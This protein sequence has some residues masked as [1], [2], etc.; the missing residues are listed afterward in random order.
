MSTQISSLIEDQL[1][2][3]IVSEYEN[4]SAILEAY[5]KQQES[6]GQPLD[7]IGNLT[8]YRDIDFYEKNLLKESTTLMMGISSTATSML[9]ADAT[10]FP[11]RNGYF[12]IGDEICFY[13]TRTDTEFLDVSRGISG[14]TML[15]DL[16]TS[17]TFV[18]SVAKNHS[19]G[20][21]VYNLSH[22]FLYAFVKAFEREYL[23]DVPEVY[24]KGDIDK[25]QLIKNISD[26][27]K[28]KG[29]DKS[30]RF[31]FNTIV[32]RSA[33]DIP[34]TYYPKENT[35]KVSEST[36]D[37][38]FTIQAVILSG[39][40]EWLIGQTIIQ[41]ADKNSPDSPYAS[42]AI[43][44]VS[45]I[46]TVAGYEL[47]D[48]IVNP[49]TVNGNFSIPER[50]TL[51]RAVTTGL[52]I[53]DTITVDSTLGWSDQVGYLQIN[54][55]II[56][57]EGKSARQFVINERGT[58]TRTHNAGDL[59]TNYSNVKSIT[60]QGEVKVL[61]YGI[62]TNL[63][64]TDPQPYSQ[65]GDRVQVSKP[66]F[67]T[68][69]PIIYDELSNNV[70]WKIN[71]TGATPTTP[72]NPGV[73]LSLQKYLADVSA[74]YEDD[75]YYYIATSSYPSTNTF[76]SAQQ[77]TPL[78][79]ANQL[80]L[81]PKETSTTPEVYKTSSRDIGIFVDG[82]IA[83][84]YKS[85]ES[86]AYGNIQNYTLTR[87]GSGYTK[88]PFVLINGESGLAS[89]TLAGDTV[90]TITTTTEKKYTADPVV[91][92]VSGRY[93]QAEAIVTSGEITS[94]RI[95][96]AGEYYSAPP[97][98]VIS[99]LAG[100][101]RFAEYRARIS[102]AGQ[103]LEFEKVSGGKFY[104]QENVRVALVAEGESNPAAATASI[105]RWVKNRFFDKSDILDD[106]GGFAIKDLIENEYYYGV[107]TNP[108]RLRF[109]LGDNLTSTTLVETSTLT[110]SPIL[111]FAYDGNPIYG[112]YGYSNPLDKDSS[113]ARMNSGYQLKTG[114]T[115]GPID[116]PYDMGTF[117][118]DYEWVATVNT[119][120]TR[121]DINN[122]RFCVTPE[123][124][125]GVYAYFLT[126]DSD[127]N[128]V[129]PYILGD[130]FYSLPVRS[131]YE[132]K[133]TQKSIPANSKRL[134][135]PG[136]DK[137]GSNELIFIDAV[138]S[139]SVSS[140]KV[141]DSQPNF[142]VGSR[143]FVDDSDNRGFGASGIVSSTEGKPVV[144]IESK[145]TK[146]SFIT[147]VSS[148][149]AFEGDIITQ[150]GTGATGELI[151]DVAEE[152]EMTL[153]NVTGSFTPGNT[154]SSSSEVINILLSQDSTYTQGETLSLVLF[155]DPTTEI[156]SGE[157]LVGTVDQNAVRLKVTNGDFFDFT[158][159]AEGEVILKSSD[160]GNTPGSEIV[161]INKLSTSID[162]ATVDEDIAI[163]T[164][165]S[166][167]DFG[168]GDILNIEID[169]DEAT[170][171][172]TYYVTKKKFQ[173]IQLI[174]QVYSAKI[175]DTGIGDTTIIGLGKDYINGTY[176]DVPLIF[177]NSALSRDDIVQAKATVVVSGENFDG[178]GNIESI[179]VTDAGSNYRRDDLL[180]I[181]PTAVPK[182]DVTD[183]NQ[184]PSL[185]IEQ[186]NSSEVEAAAQKRFI[187]AE[188]DYENL[189]DNIL[190]EDG[191]FFDTDAGNT[192]I[193]LGH[194]DAT[195]SFNYYPADVE[196][197]PD[198]T[199]SDTIGGIAIVTSDVFYSP[200][201]PL[202]QFE[203]R[204][205]NGNK[206]PEYS[207][208]VGSTITIPALQN[209][210]IY[211]VSDYTTLTGTDGETP[212][213]DEYSIAV[214]SSTDQNAP[215]TFTPQTTGTY[216]YICITHPNA[217]GKINVFPAPTGSFPLVNV[218]AVGFGRGRVDMVVTNTFGISEND[219]ISVGS[220]VVRV[221][222]VNNNDKKLTVERGQEN[223]DVVDHNDGKE[224]TSFRP[225][226]NFTPGARI[227]GDTVND[228]RVVSYDPE[229]NLLIVNWDYDST[230]PN[231]I[232]PVSSILD[233]GTPGKIA[234]VSQAGDLKEKLLFSI[235]QSNFL[236][237]PVV[238][239]QKYY[240]YKFDV[241]HPSMLNSYLDISTSPNF[242]VFTEEKETGLAEPGSPGAFVKIRLGYGP[243]IG[244][245][246]R[247]DVNFTSY[248]YFLTNSSTD[249][250]GSFLRIIDDPL[251]GRKE[252]KFTTPTKL[253]Y[254]I[255]EDPQYDGS[256][257]I[258]Y[259][260]KSIGKIASISLD[261]LGNDY[262]KLPLIK[263]VVPAVGYKATVDVVRDSATNKIV[264]IDIIDPGQ[265]YSK[266]EVVVT[267]GDG[268][269]LH[270]IADQYLG[271]ITQIRILNP[272]NYTSTPAVEIIETDNKLFFE[273]ESIG[274]PQNVKF[275]QYGSGYHSDDTIMSTYQSPLVFALSNFELDA[276]RD[277]EKIQQY[278][279]DILTAEGTVAKS[280]WRTGS[281][282]LR[283]ERITG[284]FM[285]G[286]QIIGK[287]RKKTATISRIISS[288][289]SPSIVTRDKTL[290]T[291]TSDRGKVSSNSQ[292]IHDSDFY[293]DYSYVIRSRTP[294]NNWRNIIKDTTHPAG[295]KVFG[296][297]YMES[298]SKVI[299]PSDQITRK[300]TTFLAGPPLS[301][302]SLST[303]RTIQQKVLKVE[304]SRLR[305][306]LGS[307]STNDFDETLI[308]TREL[309]LTPAFDGRYDPNTGLKIGTQQF[310]ILDKKSGAAYAP[311]N[312]QE[313]LITIDGVAQRPGRSYKV[314]GNQ[315]YFYEA[316]MGERVLED[317]VVPPQTAYIRSFKFREDSDN[318][319]YLKR[320]KNIA[321]SFDGR[322]R[323]FDLHWE[324]G[325]IVKTQV[326]EDLFIYL[327]GI[328]QQGSYE[329]RRFSSPN[330]TDRIA[331]AK[332]PKNYED[333]YDDDAFPQE[334]QNETYFYG[335]GVGLYERFSIDER[336]IPYNDS[337][338]SYIVYDQNNAAVNFTD[339]S[340]V[341]VY[342]DGVLQNSELSYKIIGASIKFNQPIRF[343]EQAD[344]TYI[345]SR[346]DIIRLYGKDAKQTVTFFNYE[347]D[348]FYNRAIVTFTGAGTY[349]TISSWYVLNTTD[350]TIVKQG[351][352]VWG[353]L[354]SIQPGTGNNWSVILKS[355]NIDFVS[356]S[357]VTFDRG[358]DNPQTINFD[359][360][361]ISYV[362]SDDGD[363]ILNRVEANFIPYLSTN[364][365]F[366]S[367][368]YRGEI[369]KEHPE[370]RVGDK[371]KIDGEFE[372]RDILSSPLFARSTDYR[373]SGQVSNSF[374]TKV[375]TSDYNGDKYGEGLSVSAEITGG[376]VVKL[377]WNQ[378]DLS[379]FFNNNILVNPTAYNYYASPI[380][381]FVPTNGEGG[382]AKA[383]VVV[384]G[385]QIIDVVL[386]DGG[387]G[388]TA[389]PKIIVSR[390][391]TVLR[392]NNHPEFSVRRIIVG[393]GADRL[394]ATI[395]S[396]TTLV[397][398]N[399]KIAI[400]SSVILQ[401]PNPISA[402]ILVRR[403]MQPVTPVIGMGFPFEQDIIT[404]IQYVATTQPPAAS[405]QP[406]YRNLNIDVD[407]SQRLDI[408]K[409]ITKS[410][411]TGVVAVNE[412]NLDNPGHFDQGKLG[413][414][415]SSFFDYLF[416]DVGYANVSGI[417]LEQLEITYSQFS[418]ISEGV[419]SWMNNA[420][421]NN[422]S[423]T[424][425]GTLFNPG[426]PSIQETMSY[427]DAPVTDVA[428]VVYL[429]STSF[430]PDSGKILIGKELVTYTGKLADRLTGV[431]R[432]VDGTAAEAHAAGTFVRTIGVETTL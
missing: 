186:T 326:N 305:R 157:I 129:Y 228:P 49:N 420:A 306:G 290:G 410:F 48:L 43:E 97:L 68:K 340:N 322:T 432:G 143:I 280:G 219:L 343:S 419:D 194:D 330:K 183:L 316:P 244:E 176:L 221:T 323:I 145:D 328:L 227:G 246:T 260:G 301:V 237:N 269:G 164:T 242:N 311:Y 19:S 185:T 109:R 56:K 360:Y 212:I 200:G 255:A 14:T 226:Y 423:F 168:I 163:L 245:R 416:I 60:P 266:P 203:F 138:T 111:G 418:G 148:F 154:I 188:S 381:N 235:D 135:V 224:L 338:N 284:V 202:P 351:D 414:T 283:L 295:F 389:P 123:Y 12:K 209:H 215:L 117:V 310:T 92:L 9:V 69:N 210:A 95:I 82:S 236:T 292:R 193:L 218:N 182:V 122:G 47:F 147:T 229:T 362:T 264:Q 98:V 298:D 394:V 276:F 231:P 130:N 133:V 402:S 374:Y 366:D 250:E 114:R 17:S 395:Q 112:P 325:S 30:I 312:E 225:R 293:Q 170:T 64:V 2:G 403:E 363:R 179:T 201:A 303:R 406:W 162:V 257:D 187:V 120:K 55:E 27:Y 422:S 365:S 166:E 66:G 26:F 421:I 285:S 65:V 3:F 190:P 34:T 302:S 63:E 361:T 232:T 137:N 85:E 7:I 270:A 198:I 142:Q 88:A 165:E 84:G 309:S 22:L 177:S 174:P 429:P 380:L 411:Q 35:L 277:G 21:E 131:N 384:Y 13:K 152:T 413:T 67:E 70:R 256:G 287:S 53:G 425:D 77:P 272:G 294:V 6:A 32:S 396:I 216:Y 329:I 76:T 206:N 127:N 404:R 417:S 136:T 332:A 116:A 289:F 431:V 393:G 15:G 58:I 335:H 59:V 199:T 282:I 28:V 369:L 354:I 1:P 247:Q 124:P 118:D 356:G 38:A 103:I 324:D 93:G 254:S 400:E 140:V 4:F 110:H 263:G 234:I 45:K 223:T 44:N 71:V 397:P 50:T 317:Q 189:R 339:D 349:D 99:D 368:D 80:K 412:L 299:M 273:S 346:V 359:N 372:F 352:N 333:L 321:D 54:N 398:L 390:G 230:N 106:N 233:Q 252:V 405:T 409:D 388:Y 399:I 278:T 156:A 262:D 348:V 87:R 33:D 342:V 207:I 275:I 358:D 173:D 10:S 271:Q 367:F 192:F 314:T 16:H 392:E 376:K 61:L 345:N 379:F 327:D 205:E 178:S 315:L 300:V 350:K 313:L 25:R 105:Y 96:N 426:I 353:E 149:Y 386:I 52:D 153:R 51:D 267:E 175:N 78:V 126:I 415:V 240:S 184:S 347:P 251:A 407:F 57:Y 281:N 37:S 214:G 308:R 401:S 40:A 320:L 344:G 208:R 249:T 195:F 144:S 169:P 94:I 132:S 191:S 337:T 427:L 79:D 286:Q 197:Y 387:S 355:Q 334:L 217:V 115:D 121:L 220:E 5:Y 81:I 102:T 75:Q 24:L 151:R 428:T 119:G 150:S 107:V 104:T 258:R 424:T 90:N 139:G 336:L 364:D 213:I 74:I 319:R 89:S 46:G 248:Y 134:F 222:F 73:G 39:N 23:V 161:I 382:G 160:L 375:V 196:N 31:I 167:H 296:E 125:D 204:D 239:I 385:G 259:T 378:R 128:P 291:F 288:T 29:S 20:D 141:E 241:S 8:T 253:V 304:D 211:F 268:S 243:N 18:S 391:Y 100:R 307:V 371:I 318:A 83:F 159:Y 265:G 297:V 158:D 383:S 42:V 373:E 274:I 172:T 91:E 261:N 72:L 171:E 36:W 341:Y 357:S 180:T 408:E 155:S 279:N 62:L 41:Q 113:I 86:I 377:N 430:L 181:E 108:K 146:A 101:G 331:F 238:N 370:L 11:R